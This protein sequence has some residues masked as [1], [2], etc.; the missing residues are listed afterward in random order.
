MAWDS[1]SNEPTFGQKTNNFFENNIQ[2]SIPLLI[3]L[4][5]A[6]KYELVGG[7]G[8]LLVGLFY[9]YTFGAGDFPVAVPAF[10]IGILFII[11]WLKKRKK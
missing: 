11:D 1:V 5:I 8:F 4:I 10:L 6:W 7:I 3:M 2:T 9:S